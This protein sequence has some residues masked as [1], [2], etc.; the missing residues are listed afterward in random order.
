MQPFR[1]A[2]RNADGLDQGDIDFVR[3]RAAAQRR[4]QRIANVLAYDLDG[5]LRVTRAE[6]EAAEPIN[7][8]QPAQFRHA[9]SDR[10]MAMYD[11]NHDG[12]IEM[13]EV[14]SAPEPAGNQFQDYQ[15]SRLQQML[16]LGGGQRLTAST[17]EQA[18][19]RT[20]E[21]VDK[22]HNGQISQDEY[23]SVRASLAPTLPGAFP[24]PFAR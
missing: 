8:M 5:D 15:A 17:L 6:I 7:P 21:S 9:Q 18:A 23:E 1:M 20:F 4:A 16:T 3:K 19:Q 24:L 12:V 22:D 10:L 13:K 2:D 11:L 14:A